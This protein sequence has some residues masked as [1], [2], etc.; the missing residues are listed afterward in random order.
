MSTMIHRLKATGNNLTD[1]QQVQA[2]IR[3]LPD[4]WEHMKRT[5]DYMFCNQASDLK[6]IGYN[7]TDW[8]RDLVEG[9]SASGYAFL[10]NDDSIFRSSKKQAC[11]TLSTMELEHI[12]CSTIV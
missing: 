11:I 5:V 8:E 7:D 6:M 10:L 12:A 2:G 4:S 9:K 1:E 3:S